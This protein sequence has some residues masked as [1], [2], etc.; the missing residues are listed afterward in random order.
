MPKLADVLMEMAQTQQVKD[1]H[2]DEEKEVE[3]DGCKYLQIIVTTK[4][5]K[6][7]KLQ[8]PNFSAQWD[9]DITTSLTEKIAQCIVEIGIGNEIKKKADYTPEDWLRMVSK[10]PARETTTIVEAYQYLQDLIFR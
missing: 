7:V 2:P 3:I 9:N 1:F 5:G 8:E 10:L 6:I 4:G